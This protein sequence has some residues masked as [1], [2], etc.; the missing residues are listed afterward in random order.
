MTHISTESRAADTAPTDIKRAINGCY[1]KFH[2]RH[3]DN[4]DDEMNR[5][6]ARNNLLKL[7]PAERI[8][9]EVYVLK[10]LNQ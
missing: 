10:T 8:H 5:S 1:E 2:A 7:T 9:T 6:A 4:P 3:R